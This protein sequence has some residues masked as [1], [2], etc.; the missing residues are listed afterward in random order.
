MYNI[1][2]Y[3][4]IYIYCDGPSATVGL[5]CRKPR[6]TIRTGSRAGDWQV[7]EP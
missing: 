6:T 2:I 3:I 7:F 5:K 1:Y 4:Y